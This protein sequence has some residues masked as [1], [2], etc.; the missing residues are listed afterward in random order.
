MTAV[1]EAF[2]RRMWAEG[3]PVPKIAQ[4][5]ALPTTTVQGRVQML[6]LPKRSIPRRRAAKLSPQP[7][8]T[9]STE[10]T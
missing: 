2:I 5:L 8:H 1:T 10:E 7:N 9:Q 3:V 4:Y 6:K